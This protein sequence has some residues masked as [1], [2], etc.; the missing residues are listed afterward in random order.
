MKSGLSKDSEKK[1]VWMKGK[2][3]PGLCGVSVS[4]IRRD[5]FIMVDC[6]FQNYYR[7]TSRE[8]KRITSVTLSPIYAHF[9]E[10]LNGI[11]T[12]RAHREIAR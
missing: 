2:T 12:I 11:V 6:L 4:R 7:Q 10:S 9:A 5:V 1:I 8:V 3:L